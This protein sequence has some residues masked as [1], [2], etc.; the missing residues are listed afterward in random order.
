MPASYDVLILGPGPGYVSQAHGMT[1]AVTQ[2]ATLAQIA[3]VIF[4][5]PTLSE[6]LQEAVMAASDSAIYA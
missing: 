1:F 6:A 3:G 4:P 5:H 2:R